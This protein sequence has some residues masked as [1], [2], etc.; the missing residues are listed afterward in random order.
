[1]KYVFILILV[2][3]FST[4]S[5]AQQRLLED[6]VEEVNVSVLSITVDT[7][8]GEQSLG[9]GFVIGAEGYIVTNAHVVEDAQKISA[10]TIYGDEYTAKLIGLDKKT[11]VALIKAEHPLGLE[12]VHF[13]D[14]DTVRV[15]QS[16]FAIGNPYGL[17]NSVSSG[18]ISA[19][20]RD[21][22]KS[23][24]DNFLQTDAAINQGNSGGPLFDMNGEVVGINTAIF[25]EQG[26]SL[27]IGFATPANLAQW[28]IEKLKNKG[29]VERGWLGL[30]VR[31]VRTKNDAEIMQLAITEIAEDSP[32]TKAGLKVGDVIERMGNVTLKNPRSFSTEIAALEPNTK[33]KA[34]VKRDNKL[35]E[36]ELKV[37]LMPEEKNNTDELNIDDAETGSAYVQTGVEFANLGL[38]ADYD[39]RTQDFVIISLKDDADMAKKGVAVG[40]RII[41][42]DNKK[43]YG[44]ED[45]RIKL[46]EAQRKGLIELKIKSGQDIDTVIVDLGNKDESR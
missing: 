5:M 32:A 9:A 1:M 15:G 18:I 14:S 20:E 37:A 10:Q 22:E 17:G 7:L 41:A 13:A 29:V 36:L 23:T 46:K 19:K 39:E 12:P 33:L 16:V 31:S 45:F 40:N 4:P 26:E 21:I 6:V 27:G 35:I 42:A 30:S 28:V 2:I 34:T 38:T 43:I 11:D 44:I 24:Y 3:L 8:Q 25:A